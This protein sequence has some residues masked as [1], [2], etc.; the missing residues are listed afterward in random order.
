[1][2]GFVILGGLSMLVTLGVLA[3]ISTA[4]TPVVVLV[5]VICTFVVTYIIASVAETKR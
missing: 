3:I 5:S 1:M 2:I 4:S